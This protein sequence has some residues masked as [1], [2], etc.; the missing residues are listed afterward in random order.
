MVQ[1]LNIIVFKIFKL[2]DNALYVYIISYKLFKN[3][4]ISLTY[5]CTLLSSQNVYIW[6]IL[7]I[8]FIRKKLP[9]FFIN[10]QFF[11]L[12]S[13]AF[14]HW[15]FFLYFLLISFLGKLS[16][17]EASYENL[18]LEMIIFSAKFQIQIKKIINYLIYSLK[19]FDNKLLDE[20]CCIAA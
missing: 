15:S 5:M 16:N 8:I 20:K 6:C 10:N 3:P 18:L 2:N 9:S 7:C 4:L 1:Y 13:N 12:S 17:Q 11:G 19:F 14:G